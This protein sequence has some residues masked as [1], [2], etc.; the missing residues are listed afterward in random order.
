MATASAGQAGQDSRRSSSARVANEE[1]VLA[2][3]EILAQSQLCPALDYAQYACG[4]R[5]N[6]L[7]IEL[8]AVLPLRII[9]SVTR[10]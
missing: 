2:I 9:Q 4:Q 1:V 8:A 3:M 6:V 7:G 10:N 5:D